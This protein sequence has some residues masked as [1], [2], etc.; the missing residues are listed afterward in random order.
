M[1]KLDAGGARVIWSVG[2]S[3]EPSSSSALPGAGSRFLPGTHRVKVLLAL[4]TTKKWGRQGEVDTFTPHGCKNK[5]FLPSTLGYRRSESRDH[6]ISLLSME[7][8]E[9]CPRD[10][11]EDEE[12]PRNAGAC[13]RRNLLSTDDVKIEISVLPIG[14]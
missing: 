7:T 3:G 13:G 14:F 9:L 12:G 5:V 1:G 8:Q 11:H 4:L 2:D 10:V 6:G